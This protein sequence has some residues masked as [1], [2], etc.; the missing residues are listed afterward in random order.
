[1]ADKAS[2]LGHN[3]GDGTMAGGCGRTPSVREGANRGEGPGGLFSNHQLSQTWPCENYLMPCDP[4]TSH[5]VPP[6]KDASLLT[7]LNRGFQQV[8]PWGH[9][10]PASEPQQFHLLSSGFV[11]NLCNTAHCFNPQGMLQLDLCLG[12]AP[13]RE[14]SRWH[15][16][17]GP[18]GGMDLT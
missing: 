6:L 5:Q 15:S 16:L 10:E 9:T 12:A 4:M 11:G 13:T 1:V 8:S 18:Q 14:C 3:T 7:S 2:W 17:V